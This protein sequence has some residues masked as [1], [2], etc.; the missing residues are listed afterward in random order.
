MDLRVKNHPILGKDER[1][2]MVTIEVD[3]KAVSA[4]EGEPI[5]VALLASGRRVLR[6]T[7]KRKEPRGVFCAI[8]QC[9][10]CIMT[11]NGVPNIRTCVT[12]VEKRMKVETQEGLGRWKESKRTKRKI[13]SS[14]DVRR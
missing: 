1:E 14:V 13:S 10:D 5:A 6:R 12:P 7:R 2:E 11:V 3:G 8:G 9:T 4:Y